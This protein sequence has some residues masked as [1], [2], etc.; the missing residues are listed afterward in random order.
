MALVKVVFKEQ[1]KRTPDIYSFRFQTE[2]RIDFR[3]G[4]FAKIVFDAE[5]LNNR[6]LNKYLSFSSSPGK[7]YVEFTKKISASK[8]S[9]SLLSLKPQET[10]YLQAPLGNCVLRDDY[11]KISFLIGGIG[12]TPVVSIIEYIFENKL[13]IDSVLFYSNRTLKDIAF[14]D[15]LDRWVNAKGISVYYIITDCKTD[16][17]AYIQGH[18]NR[19]LLEERVKD[20]PERVV[21]AFGPP[22]MVEA[23]K[24]LCLSV[25][26]KI[27]N[28]KTENFLGY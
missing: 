2:E 9:Q 3:P 8:F 22:A 28:I 16:E 6:D 18:I 19:D 21:F 26:C 25:G 5:N 12:I 13:G 11:K 4:Q 24:S 15:K 1:V 27:E 14:K 23:M 7:E 20:W 17:C 10:I